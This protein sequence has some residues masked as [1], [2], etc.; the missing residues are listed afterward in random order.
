M[1][2]QVILHTGV[3]DSSLQPR[4]AQE[5]R[6]IYASLFGGVPE[7]IPVDVTEIPRGRFFSA[8]KPSRTSLVGGSV[9]ARTSGAE[10]TRLMSEITTMWCQ[11]T[12]CEPTEI[13][14]SISDA[15]A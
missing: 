5:V 10:R 14:V 1:G 4:L 12:G 3:I 15:A 8:G 13:V 6:R 7:R 9:P 11:V 2:F